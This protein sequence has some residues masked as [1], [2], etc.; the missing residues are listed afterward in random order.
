M[1]LEGI[2]VDPTVSHRRFQFAINHL[3]LITLSPVDTFR[4]DIIIRASHK[5]IP[6]LL[7]DRVLRLQPDILNLYNVS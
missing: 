3:T 4:F 7:G 6:V 1:S 5:F 2:C